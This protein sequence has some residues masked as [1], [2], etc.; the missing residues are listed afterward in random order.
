MMKYYLFA[1][2]YKKNTF[3]KIFGLFHL[4]SKKIKIPVVNKY[5][6]NKVVSVSKKSKKIHMGTVL[7][8][9][10]IVIQSVIALKAENWPGQE[11]GES[12]RT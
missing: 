7:H 8:D 12:V 5:H 10:T 2:C 6:Q 11:G 3:F 9:R 4:H 1:K